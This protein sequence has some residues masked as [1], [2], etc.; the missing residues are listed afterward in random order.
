MV[1][2][3]F[4]VETAKYERLTFGPPVQDILTVPPETPLSYLY[5]QRLIW[6]QCSCG[7]RVVYPLKFLEKGCIKSCG[8]LKAEKAKNR[9]ARL[10][11]RADRVRL[12]AELKQSK[13]AILRA[14]LTGQYHMVK[15]LERNQAEI[16]RKLR[17]ARG[18]A[19]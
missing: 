10:S 11:F 9:A 6:C 19:Y 12:T 3:V 8:C 16:A 18:K 15:E 2:K 14:Q 5:G 7:K 13:A 1:S 17:Y 4:V